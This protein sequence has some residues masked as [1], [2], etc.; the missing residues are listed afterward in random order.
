M[1]DDEARE[2]IDRPPDFV[3]LGTEDWK[4]PCGGLTVFGGPRQTYLISAIAE[5]WHCH[6]KVERV[7]PIE[8]RTE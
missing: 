6:R 4:C 3:V 5:C 7:W 8:G 1:G 2:L